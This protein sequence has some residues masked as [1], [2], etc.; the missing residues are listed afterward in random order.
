M[1][2]FIFEISDADKH[3]RRQ[4]LDWYGQLAQLSAL[5]PLLG[6]LVY[7]LVHRAFTQQSSRQAI[8]SSPYLKSTQSRDSTVQRLETSTRTFFWWCGN[9]AYFFDYPLGKNGEILAAMVWTGWLLVLCAV[10][11]GE[12]YMHLAKR[13]GI[14]G[15]SQLP[16]HYL[17]AWKSQWSP[18]ALITG[19]SWEELNRI[20][21]SLGRII[22]VLFALHAT[23]YLNFFIRA[24]FIYKRIKDRDVILGLLAITSFTILGSTALNAVRNASYR[25]FFLAHVTIAI[26]IFP[27]LYFH[28]SH[29]RIYLLESLIIYALGSALRRLSTTTITA[30]ATEVPGTNLL[31][32]TFP[33]LQTSDL[34]H[35]P[36]NPWSPGQHVYLSQH[37]SWLATN[38]FTI[39]S[40]PTDKYIRV[41][42][43]VLRGNTAS[44][45]R[46]AKQEAKLTL[47]MEGP[48]GQRD[49][50]E[51]LL[52]C[53]R[54]LFVA[55]GV[56]AT[57][58]LP[59]WRAVRG[60]LGADGARKV[61]RG[62]PD[63]RRVVEEVFGHSKSEK[64]AVYVCGPRGMGDRL[65]DEVGRY[66]AEGRDVAFWNEEF[67][68]A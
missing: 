54:I 39:A 48:Y 46:G 31:E 43:R 42:L 61:S 3:R 32:L 27:I 30:T 33:N 64:V 66:V 35:G 49:H 5:V 36:R 38:P 29:L 10:Q 17:L 44:L 22:T 56:G 23:S 65:R 60:K 63:L 25:I 37:N 7:R 16:F 12:D 51:E 18:I 14:V 50:V 52:G 28:V 11:T 55:G 58:V 68:L 67:G 19:R 1:W 53:D 57:F 4:L 6:I 47:R 59:L 9:P 24:G 21:Q 13:F 26:L 62:R 20:H 41:L 15:A 40:L 45:H 2:R 34:K 8:P